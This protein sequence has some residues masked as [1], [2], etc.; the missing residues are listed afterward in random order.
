MGRLKSWF[1][2]YTMVIEFPILIL[3]LIVY[4]LGYI[5]LIFYTIIWV[6]FIVILFYRTICYLFN[7]G[8]AQRINDYFVF[9]NLPYTNLVLIHQKAKK[10]VIKNRSCK[11]NTIN[12]IKTTEDLIPKIKEN[13]KYITFTHKNILSR[14]NE[15]KDINII[16]KKPVYS[17]SFSKTQEQI[18]QCKKKKCKKIN[19]CIYA[20]NDERDFYFVKFT[21]EP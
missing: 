1:Y 19:K 9:L 15:N 3:L 21:Y 11:E 4:K 7:I 8:I 17:Q 6:V 20:N 5:G 14:L 12:L 18:Y 16:T 2:S 10:S 13:K